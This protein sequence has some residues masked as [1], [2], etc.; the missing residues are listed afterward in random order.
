MSGGQHYYLLKNYP[1]GI[2]RHYTPSQGNLYLMVVQLLMLSMVR[3]RTQLDCMSSP[4]VRN[5]RRAFWH[6]PS[7]PEKVRRTY[8]QLT[9]KMGWYIWVCLFPNYAK[10]KRMGQNHPN[11]YDCVQFRRGFQHRHFKGLY[12]VKP[13][14]RTPLRNRDK[15]HQ[16]TST[17]QKCV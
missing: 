13:F 6:K 10:T 8:S 5:R 3:W 2:F 12:T 16:L 1:M 9:P 14:S 4:K 15:G 7:M 11:Q 17:S